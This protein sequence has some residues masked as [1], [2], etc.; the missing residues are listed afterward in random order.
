MYITYFKVFH[1]LATIKLIYEIN[2]FIDQTPCSPD[3]YDDEDERRDPS[4]KPPAERIRGET[5]V[6][7][8]RIITEQVNL[9]C[10]YQ[11]SDIDQYRKNVLLSLF[12]KPLEE[13]VSAQE[14]TSPTTKKIQS[15]EKLQ[16][17]ITLLM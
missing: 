12:S 2:N 4:Y 10:S 7:P 9:Q 11:L 15:R 17:S 16:S 1:Y 3:A 5:S 6:R 8:Q 14:R 13:R